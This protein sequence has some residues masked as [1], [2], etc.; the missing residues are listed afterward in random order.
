MNSSISRLVKALVDGNNFTKGQIR[1]RFGIR[2]VTG[3]IRAV[4]GQGYAVYENTRYNSWLAPMT[5]FQVGTP[6]RRIVAAGNVSL[7]LA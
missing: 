4:R 6:T 7:G 5:V 1:E 3:A 2:N